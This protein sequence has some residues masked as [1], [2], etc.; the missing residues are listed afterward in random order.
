MEM[1]GQIKRKIGVLGHA[2]KCMLEQENYLGI[3]GY[4][5]YNFI[6]CLFHPNEAWLRVLLLWVVSY[7]WK[8]SSMSCLLESESGL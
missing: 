5:L 1:D 6:Q 4:F 3:I 2:Q 8:I 7:R